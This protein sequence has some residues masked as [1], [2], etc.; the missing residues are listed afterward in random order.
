MIKP[1][2]F[3][4]PRITENI[5]SDWNPRVDLKNVPPPFGQLP[6]KRQPDLN[7][8][9]RIGE[10]PPQDWNPRVDLKNAPPPFEDDCGKLYKTPDGK[11]L[12]NTTYELNG[13]VYTTDEKGRI[14]SCESK[15]KRTPEN[16]R[17]NEAQ[18]DVG[19]ED[20]K[21]NDQGGHII[22]RDLGGDSGT[23]NL[24][25]MDSRINQSDYKRMENDIKNAL[26][27][28]KEVSI[29]TEI[30]YEGDSERPSKIVVTVTID[31]KDTVYTFDNDL[32]GSLIEKVKETGTETDVEQVQAKLDETSGTITSIKETYDEN[33][34]L[35]QTEVNITYKDENG[36]NQRVK[37]VYQNGN[38]GLA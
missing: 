18:G 10:K 25:A 2:S 35:V 38:G 19:G 6:E 29:K 31:G 27:K 21:P 4:N 14:I 22:G 5:Q 36:D 11:L 30:T 13:N 34:N 23:G 12:P 20:R 8:N 15:P 37:V 17:D 7:D 32:D 9:P 33:G 24:I 16:P 28:G 26:E 1:E 3:D